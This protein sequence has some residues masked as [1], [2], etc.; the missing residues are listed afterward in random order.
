MLH[1]RTL[2][3][4]EE[5]TP[6]TTHKSIEQGLPGMGRVGRLVVVA[7]HVVSSTT[8][9][10]TSP[11]CATATTVSRS[12]TVTTV[13]STATTSTTTVTTTT[14]GGPTMR[15]QVGALA[16]GTH[17]SAGG[18]GAGADG[19][20]YGILVV[21]LVWSWLWCRA[22][23][24]CLCFSGCYASG[25]PH[26]QGPSWVVTFGVSTVLLTLT[27]EMRWWAQGRDRRL[28]AACPHYLVVY[29]GGRGL[30]YLRDTRTGKRM[31]VEDGMKHP[32]PTLVHHQTNG[33]WLVYRQVRSREAVVYK[34]PTTLGAELPPTPMNPTVVQFPFD[35]DEC[36]LGDNEDHLWLWSFGVMTRGS[37]P[38]FR[39]ALIDLA[40]T[41]LLKTL[42]VLG[43]AALPLDDD[44]DSWILTPKHF[45]LFTKK[46]GAHL[47]AVLLHDAYSRNVDLIIIEEGT[48]HMKKIPLG[49][50]RFASMWVSPLNESQFS[51]FGVHKD[52]YEVWDAADTTRPA[53]EKKC[54]PGC[55]TTNQ[56][57]V[58]GGLLFQMSELKNE[59]HVT[60]E[61]SGDHVITL[62]FFRPAFVVHH[63]SFH[64][65]S[66]TFG[67]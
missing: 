25:Y 34:L 58:E 12:A 3:T 36:R 28:F 59:M 29:D 35:L 18:G 57:F 55:T 13:T 4:A 66:N 7:P 39:L 10:V 32:L 64:L 11:P 22:R 42:V 1:A 19:G 8:T 9:C 60:E 2:F 47:F 15:D 6:T 56:A 40:Q 54:L 23:F 48:G 67:V 33:K 62:Q 49:G 5:C 38:L 27:H 50:D 24:F 14:T 37:L 46:N 21:R 43:S 51:V 31:P 63:H 30:Y 26:T 65:S 20:D 44:R 17:P 41:Q 52:T 53:R 61:S 45:V 16:M